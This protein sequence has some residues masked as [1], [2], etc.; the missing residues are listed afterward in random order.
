MRALERI[1]S[2]PTMCRELSSQKWIEI[3]FTA[4]EVKKD[5]HGRAVKLGEGVLERYLN[6]GT[7]L[8]IFVKAAGHGP[9]K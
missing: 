7:M 1:G 6:F 9:T 5:E 4:I 3:P 8:G 2:L